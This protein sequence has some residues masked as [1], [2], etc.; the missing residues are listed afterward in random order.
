[1]EALL[2][3]KRP[4]LSPIEEGVNVLTSLTKRVCTES[5]AFDGR[6]IFPVGF[7]PVKISRR[8]EARDNWHWTGLLVLCNESSN[9]DTDRWE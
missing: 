9:K 5:T 3:L 6:L 7:S 1:M 4:N 2:Q 8:A